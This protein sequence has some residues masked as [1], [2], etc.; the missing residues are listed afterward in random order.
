MTRIVGSIYRDT[1][2]GSRHDDKMWG[3]FG[4]D[5]VFGRG[6]SVMISDSYLNKPAPGTTID[7]WY[8]GGGGAA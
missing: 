3:D 5:F 7:D 2:T 4:D 8:F 1:L 6:G